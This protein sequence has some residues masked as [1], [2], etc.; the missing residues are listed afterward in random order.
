MVYCLSVCE[1]MQSTVREHRD[2]G[3][4]GGVFSRYNI[5]KVH[6]SDVPIAIWALLYRHHFMMASHKAPF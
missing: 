3:H 5:V 1:Q 4:A 2:G 6:A